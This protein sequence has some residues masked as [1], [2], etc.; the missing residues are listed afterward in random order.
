MRGTNGCYKKTED[1][2]VMKN[3]IVFIFIL[4]IFVLERYHCLC[5]YMLVSHAPLLM[6]LSLI[7]QEYIVSYKSLCN[8]PKDDPY[9]NHVYEL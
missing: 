8:I 5:C 3:P 6:Y 2:Q 7:V 4:T 9:C 1:P